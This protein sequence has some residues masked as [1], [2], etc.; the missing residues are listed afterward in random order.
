[1]REVAVGAE[2]KRQYPTLVSSESLTNEYALQP[3]LQYGEL[4][5]II[6]ELP[7]MP[8]QLRWFKHQTLNLGIAGS[9]PA[10][11]T[12]NAF[13]SV[14]Q[15]LEPKSLSLGLIFLLINRR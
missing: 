11:G 9:S 14:A 15:I 10:T 2:M 3:I 12:N 5:V 1:M 6:M 7:N 4:F 8:V 13:I